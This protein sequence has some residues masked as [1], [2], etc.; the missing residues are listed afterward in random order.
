MKMYR[1]VMIYTF[2]VWADSEEQ[3]TER[4]AD[5]FFDIPHEW[6][7][8][9]TEEVTDEDDFYPINERS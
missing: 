1:Q 2:D 5:V 4:C 6:V 9:H 3:A 7:P 8:A